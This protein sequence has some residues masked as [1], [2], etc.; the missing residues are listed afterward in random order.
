[1]GV[2]A[3]SPFLD[4]T[5]LQKGLLIRASHSGEEV[6][7]RNLPAGFAPKTSS[8]LLVSVKTLR[9][10]RPFRRPPLTVLEPRTV[11]Q[12]HQ[13]HQPSCPRA[14]PAPD[15]GGSAEISG[16]TTLWQALNSCNIVSPAGQ[17]AQATMEFLLC[18]HKPAFPMLLHAGKTL[19]TFL[20]S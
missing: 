19:P 18:P 7:G 8:C 3:C 1:M 10:C 12:P 20:H 6:W 14:C 11:R 5:A 13:P 2:G 17:S 9:H 4:R 16:P 15:Q